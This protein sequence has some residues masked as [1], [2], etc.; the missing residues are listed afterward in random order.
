MTPTNDGG[1]DQGI[2]WFVDGEHFLRKDGLIQ[3]LNCGFAWSDRHAAANR[4]EE[5]CPLCDAAN[6]S[7]EVK[8]LGE[9]LADTV[10]KRAEQEPKPQLPFA[11]GDVVEMPQKNGSAQLEG[12]GS[13]RIKPARGERATRNA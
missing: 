13:R 3:H 1:V 9:L 4:D 6:L 10:Q 5:S 11:V 8:R 7:A 12:T 2:E